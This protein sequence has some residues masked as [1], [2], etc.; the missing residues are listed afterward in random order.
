MKSKM[1]FLVLAMLA[2]MPAL[3]MAQQVQT[4]QQE[5]MI[6][7]PKSS[8]TAQQLADAQTKL[9]TQNLEEYSKWAQMGKAI[10][11]GVKETLAAVT[12]E[13]AKFA[14]TDVGK[15]AMFLVAWKIM[16]DDVP[17]LLNTMVGY[18]IG[19]PLFFIGG[20]IVVWSYRRMCVPRRVLVEKSADGT[21]K[22]EEHDPCPQNS[23]SEWNREAWMI[24][25]VVVFVILTIICS[26]MIFA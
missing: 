6:A 23:G 22:Y 1:M 21:K 13:T 7:V 3:A 16:A 2:L 4:P 8:L 11:I 24:A 12:G 25:H 10:G 14:E 19:I 26:I 17:T 20:I 15:V 5:E 9:V 18:L